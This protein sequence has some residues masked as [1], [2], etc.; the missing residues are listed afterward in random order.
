MRELRDLTLRKALIEDRNR[1]KN[2]VHAILAKNGIIDYPNPF[3]K[4]GREHLENLD[5]PEIDKELLN[6][7][8]SI[9]DRINKE[10]KKIDRIIRKPKRITMP[11]YSQPSP[12]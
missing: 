9:I 10:I 4:K 8:L 2:R 6:A 7:N 11:Y 3:T 1:L 12:E 5:L